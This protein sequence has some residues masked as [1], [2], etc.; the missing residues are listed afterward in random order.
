MPQREDDLKRIVA[1]ARADGLSDAQI[2]AL[3]QRYDALQPP[4]P[5]AEPK[6]VGGFVENIGKSG[7]KAV[8]DTV[9]MLDPRNWDDIMHLMAEN[10]RKE[11]KRILQ[12]GQGKPVDAYPAP[13][14]DK[15]GSLEKAGESL[16]TDPV[17]TFLDAQPLLGKTPGRLVAGGLRKAGAAT[18]AL[19][20]QMVQAA[21]KPTV[22]QLRSQAGAAWTGLQGQAEKVVDM[23]LRNRFTS[24]RQAERAI[25]NAESQIQAGVKTDPN[26]NFQPLLNPN[27]VPKSLNVLEQKARWQMAPADDVAMIRGKADDILQG[28]LGQNV[29]KLETVPGLPQQVFG[30]TGHQ[31]VPATRMGNTR[32]W[33]A[34]ITPEKLLKILRA[35]S[36]WETR[37]QFGEFKGAEMEAMKA[38][39]L[40]GRRDLGSMVPSLKPA[41]T[42]QHEALTLYPLLDRMALRTANRDM[43]GLPAWVMAAGSGGSGKGI[44]LG[45]IAEGFRRGQLRGGF[46]AQDIGRLM[47]R[48]AGAAGQATTPAMQAALL[49][50]LLGQSEEQ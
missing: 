28:P 30:P 29:P 7:F 25:K 10:L 16:Y 3:L 47:G 8:S 39:E 12:R 22:A 2:T 27:V 36:K 15:Y 48:S 38:A 20:P 23:A 42:K 43:V 17:G 11:D 19:A 26:A 44:L 18:E 13:W 32:Q 6:S 14:A 41:L 34:N 33:A 1:G 31:V 4:A 35:T 24:S 50:Q 5:P 46:A 9:Q 49:A 21:L 37:K 45:L 40:A